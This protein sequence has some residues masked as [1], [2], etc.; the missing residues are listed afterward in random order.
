VISR[1]W[2]STKSAFQR[3]IDY[4]DIS[5]RSTARRRQARV[6]WKKRYLRAICVIISKTVRDTSIVREEVAY[7]LSIDTKI[8]D[9]G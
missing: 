8:N 2:E 3:Y 5:R 9:L 6:W 1:I 4:V 7:A